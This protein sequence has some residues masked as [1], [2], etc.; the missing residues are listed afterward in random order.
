[1]LHLFGQKKAAR[2]A[3]DKVRNNMEEEVYNKLEEDGVRKM[4]YKLAHDRDDM[5]EVGEAV[6]KNGGGRLVTER[7]AE[8]K[9]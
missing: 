1:M 8:L 6:I 4:T 9:V 3:V 7:G 5:R 2:R